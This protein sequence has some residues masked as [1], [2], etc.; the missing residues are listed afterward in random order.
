MKR[1]Q[2][3]IS[4]FSLVFVALSGLVEARRS[5]IG[6]YSDFVYS[7]SGDGGWAIRNENCELRGL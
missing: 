3:I 1:S 7:F 5:S 4:S 6:S 2:A